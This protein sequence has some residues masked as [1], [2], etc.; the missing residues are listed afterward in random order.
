MNFATRQIHQPAAHYNLGTG[1]AYGKI[2]DGGRTRL[3]ICENGTATNRPRPGLPEGKPTM[4]LEADELEQ[5]RIARNDDSALNKLLGQHRDRLRRMAKIRLNPALNGR[6]DASD[7][8]QEAYVEAQRVIGT[9][10]DKPRVPLIVWLRHLTGQKI[11]EAHRRHLG[12][13]KRNARMEVA[14]DRYR[15]PA[16]SSMSIAIE[17]S[18]GIASPSS[19]AAQNEM[20]DKLVAMLDSMDG[21]DR[22]I[23]VPRHFEQLTNSEVAHSLGL[24]KSAASKRYV[25]ALERMQRLMS[26]GERE[27]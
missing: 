6:I 26:S 13:E 5:L 12:A 18:A 17:L 20:R 25:R 16:A 8:V 2:A 27:S 23:L 11:I 1:R 22:E 24:D 19:Q 10:L 15:T 14:I 4:E 3:G 7:I 9:Y 21:V